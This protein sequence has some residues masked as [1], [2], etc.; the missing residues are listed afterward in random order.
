MA[1]RGAQIGNKNRLGK[2]PWNKG[3]KIDKEKYPNIGHTQKHSEETRKKMSEKAKG[4][5]FSK[6]RNRKISQ[7]MKKRIIKPETIEKLRDR[8]GR[9]NPNWKEINAERKYSVDWTITLRRSIRE[10]DKYTCRL[11]G[12]Q[13]KEK[14][15]AVHHIDYDKFNCNPKNL[16]SLCQLCHSKTNGNREYYKNLLTKLT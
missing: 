11:C 16:I 8:C 6:E 15:H 14:S 12:E 13:Q 1:K 7:A 5:K 4:R 10:R 2:S 3:I 9:K